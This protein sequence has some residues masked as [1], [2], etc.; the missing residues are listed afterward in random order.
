MSESALL[1]TPGPH[2][3]GGDGARL[4]DV[5]PRPRDVGRPAPT[6]DAALAPVE[7]PLAASI[8][9]VF[10]QQGQSA[11]GGYV[12]AGDGEIPPEEMQA[13]WTTPGPPLEQS[14]PVPL[15]AAKLQTIGDLIAYY[16]ELQDPA[17]GWVFDVERVLPKA[18]MNMSVGG[19]LGEFP[20]MDQQTFHAL[21]G[22]GTYLVRVKGPTKKGG[23]HPMTGMPLTSTYNTIKILLPGNPVFVPGGQ[24]GRPDAGFG[25][26]PQNGQHMQSN[27]FGGYPG[28]FGGAGAAHAQVE[29]TAT[30][31]LGDLSGQLLNKALGGDGGSHDRDR[32]R[33]DGVTR[34]VLEYGQRT[35]TDQL[36]FLQAQ[37]ADKDR[38]LDALMDEIRKANANSPTDRLAAQA[39][40]M[41]GM[42]TRMAQMAT[43]AAERMD[44]MS[45]QHRGDIESRDRNWEDRLR[46]AR[47]EG[48]SRE[49]NARAEA[50]RER[51]RMTETFD[52][53]L[54][55]AKSD[56]EREVENHRSDHRRQIDGMNAD[57]NRALDN[58]RSDHARD[59]T[60]LAG[61]HKI[62]LEAKDAEIVR[63]RTDLAT[64][65]AE[66]GL[67]RR[68]VNKPTAQVLS[69]AVGL[70]RKVGM[71]N[72]DEIEP[73][74]EKNSTFDRLIDGMAPH[75]PKML[76]QIIGAFG[77]LSSGVIERVSPAAAAAAAAKSAPAAATQAA[78]PTQAA[79]AAASP[80]AQ[81]RAGGRSRM[82]QVVAQG[83]HS[84]DGVPVIMP[85]TLPPPTGPTSADITAASAAEVARQAQ[86]AE[87]AARAKDAQAA[88]QPAQPQQA[89]HVADPAAGQVIAEG[90]FAG[91]TTEQVA[92]WR[93]SL[94]AS[95]KERGPA[96]GS[97][98]QMEPFLQQFA[99]DATR[100][101]N[102]DE[103]AEF[104]AAH[105][106]E[107][108]KAWNF[109]P[110][111]LSWLDA[112]NACVLLQLYTGPKAGWDKAGRKAW[113]RNV[114][115]ALEAS[116]G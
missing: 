10:A 59:A 85:A 41:Q 37:N 44:R 57:H 72:K 114:W 23:Q 15:A 90:P 16:P 88:A 84:I 33:D 18:F 101:Y 77:E 54:Q 5:Q 98:Q 56:K 91:M 104:F 97:P 92:A 24:Q 63:L 110:L 87:A 68:E 12:R 109:I 71:V 112:D 89:Q 35:A 52:R 105:L 8:G 53:K 28:G 58:L 67:L 40:D 113:L 43:D 51:E 2:Q 107:E 66:L 1:T 45:A 73:E 94:G 46:L 80:A 7:A 60:M 65:Q 62:A 78:A 29:N 74:K 106:V 83:V 14:V 100:S 3:S 61:L 21:F 25:G 115:T 111:V 47:E 38:R 48:K 11:V 32:D 55:E 79:A 96:L 93:K 9:E 69:E 82:P 27:G 86:E 6:D 103:T 22:G 20:P 76:P 31:A 36:A 70:A 39:F 4:V 30:K 108:A 81:A 19:G 42:Q 49:D 50:A 75:L 34:S 17:S 13:G 116:Q 102:A 99:A 26:F 95:F 64:A